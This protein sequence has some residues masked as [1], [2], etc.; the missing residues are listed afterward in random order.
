MTTISP[1]A[2]AQLIRASAAVAI[3]I[4]TTIS[5]AADIDCGWPPSTKIDA[6]AAEYRAYARCK[7]A[8][9]N[10]VDSPYAKSIRHSE[11]EAA[12]RTAKEIDE[13]TARRKKPGVSIGM[14]AEQVR[15]ETSWGHPQHINRRITA[16]SVT[17]Q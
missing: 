15:K 10:S 1:A 4:M 17:E 2:A 8:D 12:R 16:G 14:T 13:A 9:A 7:D 5:A 3:L 11:A 6:T